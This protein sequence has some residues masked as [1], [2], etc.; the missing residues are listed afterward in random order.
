MT[1]SNISPEQNEK[2][3]IRAKANALHNTYHFIIVIGLLG[4][5]F[6]SMIHSMV[7]D[8][9]GWSF[10]LIGFAV[11]VVL[12]VVSYPF[13][14]RTEFKRI[15]I[16]SNKPATRTQIEK[17]IKMAKKEP[18]FK[19][20]FSDFITKKGDSTLTYGEYAYL[21]E[22]K[23]LVCDQAKMDNIHKQLQELAGQ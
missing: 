13:R 17:I 10:T 22:M 2:Y 3:Y 19:P 14:L 1:T 6:A 9:L 23:D 7:V 12:A 15:I 20:V 8:H 21:L 11:S 18:A 16:K 5:F 4:N